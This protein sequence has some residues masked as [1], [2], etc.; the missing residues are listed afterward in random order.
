MLYPVQRGR[1]VELGDIS[2]TRLDD[3]APKCR[4]KL[5]K[6]VV[7][8]YNE[9]PTNLNKRGAVRK[10]VSL[11]FSI[12]MTVDSDGNVEDVIHDGPAYNAG[13]GPGMKITAVNG[14]QFSPD[15]L[16]TAIDAAKSTTDP[17]QLIIANGGDVQTYPIAYHGGL[18]YPHLERDNSH[19]D[20]L[21][22][23]LRSYAK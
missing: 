6:T 12:G 22:E 19:P 11:I 16:K 2:R 3:T 4:S 23:I 1:A 8:S 20:Y 15:E 17:I 10:R 13:I 21:S 9:R 14:I 5:S 7:G 18:R